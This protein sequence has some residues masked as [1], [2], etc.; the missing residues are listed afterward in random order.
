MPNWR[1][2]KHRGY[3][4]KLKKPKIQNTK[5]QNTISESS[6]IFKFLLLKMKNHRKI[7][8]RLENYSN[9]QDVVQLLP[10][11]FWKKDEKAI[12]HPIDSNN[13]RASPEFFDDFSFSTKKMNILNL[14]LSVFWAMVLWIFGFLS[15]EKYPRYFDF[16]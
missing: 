12:K 16:W 9:I 7:L 6:K 1:K 4:S 15:L 14:W 3:F 13:F 8:K 5:A 2:S 10:L 11:F